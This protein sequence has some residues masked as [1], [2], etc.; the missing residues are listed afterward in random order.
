[1]RLVLVNTI[2][3][4]VALVLVIGVTYYLTNKKVREL[5]LQ[6]TSLQEQEKTMSAQKEQLERFK[7]QLPQMEVDS[8]I[9]SL[10]LPSNPEQKEW[11][12]FL[13][14]NV[15]KANSEIIVLE[16]D[17]P[18]DLPAATKPAK[19]R[20][21]EEQ[22]LNEETL[23]KSKVMA[24]TMEI[25]GNFQNVLAFIENLKRSHRLYR[26]DKIEGSLSQG[27]EGASES[28]LLD[29]SFELTGEMYF[30]TEETDISEKISELRTKLEQTLA[31]KLP[32]MGES[33]EE[34]L[35][36][37]TSGGTS[38]SEKTNEEKESVE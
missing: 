4:I 3:V 22:E 32:T 30:T 7:G 16:M 38:A 12:K 11:V 21:A 20:T 25:R 5:E 33:T 24:T 15:E 1:M 26:I 13:Q 31:I 34:G 17:Q 8:K 19:S 27:T 9:I 10:L 14:E 29:L 28:A 6:L 23:K 18:K 37:V 2:I 35:L 36:E